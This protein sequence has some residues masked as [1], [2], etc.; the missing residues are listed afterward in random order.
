MAGDP[1][2]PKRAWRG[3]PDPASNWTGE[4][5]RPTPSRRLASGKGSVAIPRGTGK[6][7]EPPIVR[8]NR[9]GVFLIVALVLLAILGILMV[10]APSL[11]LTT[12]KM[13]KRR[14]HIRQTELLARGGVEFALAELLRGRTEGFRD[15]F[16]PI[17]GGQVVVRVVPDAEKPNEFHIQSEAT[18]MPVQV[19]NAG[20]FQVIRHRVVREITRRYRVVRDED[21]RRASFVEGQTLRMPTPPGR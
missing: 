7:P 8:S 15:T 1:I 21:G 10:A 9:R 17:S 20:G 3:S 5:R 16:T 13:L 14:H 12:R 19:K 2:D 4:V 6:M 18:Y 11:H